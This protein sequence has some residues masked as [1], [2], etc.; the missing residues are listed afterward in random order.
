MDKAKN[1]KHYEDTKEYIQDIVTGYSYSETTKNDVS[2]YY[3]N[4]THENAGIT[5]MKVKEICNEENNLVYESFKAYITKIVKILFLIGMIISLVEYMIYDYDYTGFIYNG[6]GAVF[7]FCGM[8]LY[9]IVIVA[10]F[11]P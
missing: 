2:T 5:Y 4:L 7:I 11:Y 10:I 9:S 1:D 3:D 6:V 8:F